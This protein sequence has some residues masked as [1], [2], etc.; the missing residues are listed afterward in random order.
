MTDSEKQI[1]LGQLNRLDGLSKLELDLVNYR[2]SWLVIA[3]SFMFT[4]FAATL[5]VSVVNPA[6][7]RFAVALRIIFIVLGFVLS[8]V[9]LVSVWAAASMMSKLSRHREQLEPLSKQAEFQWPPLGNNSIEYHCG[10][11]GGYAV[12][13]V[14]LCAWLAVSVCLVVL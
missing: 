6:F 2:N 4:A 13:V 1:L 12:A 14:F 8:L 7:A 11:A 10:Q 3:Q 5:T 9:I